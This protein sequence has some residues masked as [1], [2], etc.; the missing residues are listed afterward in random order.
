[1]RL[2]RIL[3]DTY[4][5]NL[6]KAYIE[7][8]KRAVPRK[9]YNRRF[10]AREI[11]EYDRDPKYYQYTDSRPWETDAIRQNMEAYKS[12]FSRKLPKVDLIPDDQWTIFRGDIVEILT[13]PDRGKQDTVSYV[14]RERNW[15]F[16]EGMNCEYKY[17]EGIKSL[18]YPGQMYKSE[19]PLDALTG[20]ALVDPI[21]MKPTDAE[22]GYTEQ[23][24][25]I[26]KSKRSGKVIPVPTSAFSTFEFSAPA[27]YQEGPKDTRIEE[28][29]ENSYEQT[30]YLCCF[31]QD[32]LDSIASE[33]GENEKKVDLESSNYQKTYW[34]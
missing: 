23:G 20:V 9:I 2:T 16:V 5:K 17:F 7:K 8:S 34:Y 22:W 12:R 11:V 28:M 29:R 15:V 21:D 27:N 18:G 10:G 1:M 31:E 14:V 3:L 4:L 25:R 32:V 19:R 24:E 30:Q 13:G 6:P 26:R 33:K